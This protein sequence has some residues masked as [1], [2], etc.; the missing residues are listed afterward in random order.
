M[1]PVIKILMPVDLR[2]PGRGQWN[3]RCGTSWEDVSIVVDETIEARAGNILGSDVEER[4]KSQSRTA[5]ETSERSPAGNQL[6]K[7]PDGGTESR[8]KR[9]EK[10]GRRIGVQALISA[11]PVSTAAFFGEAERSRRSVPTPRTPYRPGDFTR[12]AMMSG[13][14]TIVLEPPETPT[15][16]GRCRSRRGKSPFRDNPDAGP[17]RRSHVPSTTRPTTIPERGGLAS[18]THFDSS[19]GIDRKVRLDNL[20]EVAGGNRRH[21]APGTSEPAATHSM[22]GRPWTSTIGLGWLPMTHRKRVPNPP[23]RITG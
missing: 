12:R 15:G 17:R 9:M 6:V 23:A 8:G 20:T 1:R 21:T 18:A 16:Q 10:P 7:V 14:G 4:Q 3:H 5:I 11:G 19:E 2:W 22:K 13:V